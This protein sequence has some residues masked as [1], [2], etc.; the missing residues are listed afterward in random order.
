M[1]CA[2]FGRRWQW[3]VFIAST[4]LL[5]GC[6]SSLVYSPSVQLPT[7]PLRAGSGQLMVGGEFLPET[8][9]I[10][11][12]QDAEPG[13]TGLIRY[14]F[15]D[16][17]TLQAKSWFALNNTSADLSGISLSGI[18]PFGDTG[19]RSLRFGTMISIAFLSDNENGDLAIGGTGFS[20][21][22]LAWLPISS[23]KLTLYGSFGPA[24]GVRNASYDSEGYGAILS[25]GLAY[26]FCSSLSAN[27]ECAG[28][29]A[30]DLYD[31]TTNIIISPSFDLGWKF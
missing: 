20:A 30:R 18:V 13:A 9:P 5:T 3:M 25:L 2:K 12:P 19:S 15:S 17:L 22:L 26:N 28:V 1:M 24:Y 14:A 27:L 11:V 10:A 4:V 31:L 21:S 29:L 23:D 7:S 16:H 6:A 8:R